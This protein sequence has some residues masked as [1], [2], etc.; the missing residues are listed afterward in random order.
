MKQ[1]QKELIR[2]EKQRVR[3]QQYRE[4]SRSERRPDRDDIARVVIHFLIERSYKTNKMDA[5]DRIIIRP[6]IKHL[7]KQG[8]D[9]LAS[10]EVFDDLIDK[11]TTSDWDFGSKPHLD[12]PQ[13]SDPD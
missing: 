4:R 13:S 11:Y 6:V 3:Q 9:N 12:K 8:F 1:Y 5:F 10:H 2:L 7:E